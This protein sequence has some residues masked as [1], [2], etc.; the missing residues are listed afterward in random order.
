M[1]NCFKS[2]CSESVCIKSKP[3]GKSFNPYSV[4][5]RNYRN[6]KKKIP[7]LITVVLIMFLQSVI[8]NS[9]C[10]FASLLSIRK[11]L[12]WKGKR[13]KVKLLYFSVELP[14]KCRFHVR[15]G[16]TFP[17]GLLNRHKKII[18]Q[19]KSSLTEAHFLDRKLSANKFMYSLAIL[20]WVLS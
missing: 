7:P 19:K 14:L 18:Q 8:W 12:I 9:S 10:S 15:K 6:E 20:T 17:M 13:N 1:K 4:F 11:R 3:D 2:C 16:Y 5:K